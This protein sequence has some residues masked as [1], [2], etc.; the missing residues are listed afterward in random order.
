[1]D[2]E[3]AR[4]RKTNRICLHPGTWRLHELP[5][6]RI[7]SNSK[8]PCLTIPTRTESMNEWKTRIKRDLLHRNNI[9]LCRI[10]SNYLRELKA[11]PTVEMNRV[12][13]CLMYANIAHRHRIEVQAQL[14]R[15]T[16]YLLFTRI[17][18]IL[19]FASTW[20]AT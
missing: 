18:E 8:K 14:V 5:L 12:C 7:I 17:S 15:C 10:A 11:L 16:K 2:R 19:E 1:M 13:V 4:D 20:F 9:R 6:I 3:W